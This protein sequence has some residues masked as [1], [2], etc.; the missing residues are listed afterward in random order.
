M[1]PRPKDIADIAGIVPL[2]P[3]SGALLLPHTRR[4][5]MV[6]EARYVALVDDILA[7]K[8]VVG[9][10][11]PVNDTEESPPGRD[12]PLQQVGCVGYLSGFEEL[13]QDRYMIVLEGIA[14]FD[15]VEE[16]HGDAPF[17]RGEISLSR[18]GEDIDPRDAEGEV[19]REQFLRVLRAYAEFADF[20]LN[21][22]EI[23]DTTTPALVNM[24]SMLSPCDAAEKQA[25]LEA[26][27]LR[28]RAQILMALVEMQMAHATTGAVLQ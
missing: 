23:N 21:W 28:E 20:E 1:S 6:F 8:R 27:S 25:L 13:A 7:S 18:F 16:I 5:L 17:R 26:G 24:C 14:R 22:S 11:Q 2:F 9:L 10:I 15:L 19:D 12:V 3:L 4:P